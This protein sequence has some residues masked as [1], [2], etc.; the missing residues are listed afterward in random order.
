MGPFSMSLF[1]RMTYNGFVFAECSPYLNSILMKAHWGL[2][3]GSNYT[4]D[5]KTFGKG[6]EAELQTIAHYTSF[7]YQGSGLGVVGW[8]PE[9]VAEGGGGMQVWA[10]QKPAHPSLATSC[11]SPGCLC[12]GPGKGMSDVGRQ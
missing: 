12:T 1:L 9:G 3:M 2:K 6:R 11:P 4:L 5:S 8:A 7:W 10:E